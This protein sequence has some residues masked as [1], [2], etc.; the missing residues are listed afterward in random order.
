MQAATF[1]VYLK[2][3]RCVIAEQNRL[4]QVKVLFKKAFYYDLHGN[5][6]SVASLGPL[7]RRSCSKLIKKSHYLTPIKGTVFLNMNDN[8]IFVPKF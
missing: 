6:H 7:M 3:V 5:T 8:I 2:L 4:A 1:L